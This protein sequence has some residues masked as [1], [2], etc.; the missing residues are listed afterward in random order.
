ME[1]VTNKLE[2]IQRCLEELKEQV[3]AVEKLQKVALINNLIDEVGEEETDC[4]N[5]RKA[6]TLSP[7]IRMFIQVGGREYN[8]N[9][10]RNAVINMYN[11][12]EPDKKLETLEI[13]IKPEDGKAYFVA[14]G[15]GSVNYLS[16]RYR[17]LF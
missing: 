11:H 15:V 16:L 14:N 10:I 6:K 1:N 13:Y 2:K 17:F 9:H 4:S 5:L 7:E 3:A 12:A 8:V